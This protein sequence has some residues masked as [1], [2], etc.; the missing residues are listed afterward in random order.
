V[1]TTPATAKVSNVEGAGKL[2]V[3]GLHANRTAATPEVEAQGPFP[4]TDHP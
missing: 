1:A 3:R 2:N 4:A